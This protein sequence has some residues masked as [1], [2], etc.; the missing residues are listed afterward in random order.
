MRTRTIIWNMESLRPGLAAVVAV[1]GLV[2]L[3]VSCVPTLARP[4]VTDDDCLRQYYCETDE[5]LNYICTR[6]CTASTECQDTEATGFCDVERGYCTLFC[7]GDDDCP[8]G[9]YC[10]VEAYCRGMEEVIG[11]EC[12]DA[13]GDGHPG[14]DAVRCSAGS[15]SCDDDPRNWTPS[16]CTLCL[17][18][19][20][21]GHG[22]LCDLGGDC[23]DT[24]ATVWYCADTV[25]SAVSAG[26]HHTC[27]VREDATLWCWGANASGQL[28]NGLALDLPGP[29][30]V[31]LAGDAVSVSA[32]QSAHTCAVLVG[33][34]V[35]CWGDN[36]AGQLGDGTDQGSA[37]PVQV[38][39]LAS[40][41]SV[42]A[43][44]T[45][46]CAVLDSGAA[47]CWG[48]GDS[49]ELGH[50][51]L[52]GSFEPVVVADATRI[53]TLAA[54]PGLSCAATLD[55][56]SLC[57][58]ANGFGQLGVGDTED[59]SQ[60]S[61]QVGLGDVRAV[62]VHATH[63]CAVT[64]AGG[65]WCWGGNFWGQLGTSTTD[66]TSW[67]QAVGGLT[68]AVDVAVGQAHSCAVVADGA[69]WCWGRN[70]GGALGDGTGQDH[71]L[72]V[73]VL[74]LTDA[75]AVT[76]GERHTCALTSTGAVWCW[77]VNWYG[78]LGDSTTQ[79]RLSPV[80]VNTP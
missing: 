9:T 2:V 17:D 25:W 44:G 66:A 5:R 57:W 23:D 68:E 39:P 35:W 26:A 19:D 6:S 46:T 36:G 33:G 45:H 41:A 54:G 14:Y 65:V 78:Q 30:A 7:M 48:A 64:N 13:D 18:L 59:R 43:G 67:P 51:L 55:G 56:T 15:D 71:L 49:G 1:G 37:L 22:S 11:R 72:P 20:G 60:P 76:A 75:V 24:D 28:G 62:A 69:V 27:A 34:E 29:T 52:T 70:A 63:G 74:G 32:G 42:A 12:V 77:G 4:C 47:R 53:S 73:R 16:G 38:A 21:D 58:G 80:P 8:T 40:A 79:D 10:T 31:V 61:P 3:G 50:G